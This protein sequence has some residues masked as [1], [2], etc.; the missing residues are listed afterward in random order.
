MAKTLVVDNIS[1]EFE[2]DRDG[3]IVERKIGSLEKA[4]SDAVASVTKLTTDLTTLQGSVSTKDAEIATLKKQVTD[5]ALTPEKID[6]A[7]RARSGMLDVARKMLGDA[8]IVDG[9][10]DADIQRQCVTKFMGGPNAITG[11]NDDQIAQ[12]FRTIAG[13][14]G[15]VQAA[16]GAP[17]FP[18]APHN[19]VQDAASAFMRP[20]SGWGYGGY[21]PSAAD[22]AYQDGIRDME[23]AWKPAHL[24]PAT[25][26]TK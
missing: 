6:A 20:G 12:S 19:G 11:W 18:H 25:A 21:Q 1:V 4:L 17:S 7:A 23:D 24:R 15:L 9:R 14:P 2:D 8:L 22:K 5:N 3:Q 26:A 10:S 13:M 16:P